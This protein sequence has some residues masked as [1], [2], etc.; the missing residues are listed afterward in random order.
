MKITSSSPDR[1]LKSY[2]QSSS[3]T[4]SR[5]KSLILNENESLRKES[6]TSATINCTST[7]SKILKP[8]EVDLGI[9]LVCISLMFIF[10]Q[11]IKVVPDIYEIIYCD[12]FELAQKDNEM[13]R[14]CT[15]T[16]IIDTFASLGNLF[17]CINSAGNF[18]LY[19]L[20]GKKFRDAFTQTYFSWISQG[21]RSNI[22]AN[23]PI[24]FSLQTLDQNTRMST[25]NPPNHRVSI[26][27]LRGNLGT[28]T[29][30]PIV[31]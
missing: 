16:T 23:S 26:V 12:H 10:C 31:V 6:Q 2:E 7:N 3:P 4:D 29:S 15:S 24:G 27:A 28:R 5:R 25:I 30:A 19:M 21:S 11:S 22:R 9:T 13:E 17:C 8:H 20:R 1:R 14:M 18:L